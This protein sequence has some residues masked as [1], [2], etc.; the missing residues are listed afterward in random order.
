MRVVAAE[1]GVERITRTVLDRFWGS[2]VG[3]DVTGDG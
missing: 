1:I 3:S 2:R